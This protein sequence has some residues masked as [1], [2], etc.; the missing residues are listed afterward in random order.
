MIWLRQIAQLSTTMSQA[1]RAT[2]FHYSLLA[3]ACNLIKAS[4]YT[5]FTSNLFLPSLAPSPLALDALAF[6]GG[7]SVMSTSAM[8]VRIACRFELLFGNLRRPDE[9]TGT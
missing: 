8:I 6:A 1:Q 2:A 5:F 9:S 7:A 3:T 4:C